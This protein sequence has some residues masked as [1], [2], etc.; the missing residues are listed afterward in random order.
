MPQSITFKTNRCVFYLSIL[1]SMS[2]IYIA[3]T[4]FMF[5]IKIPQSSAPAHNDENDSCAPTP[6]HAPNS[7]TPVEVKSVESSALVFTHGETKTECHFPVPFHTTPTPFSSSPKSLTLDVKYAPWFRRGYFVTS[8]VPVQTIRSHWL[9]DLHGQF[10]Y[11]LL[12]RLPLLMIIDALSSTSLTNKLGSVAS[13]I[14]NMRTFL[15][16]SGIGI[17]LVLPWGSIVFLSLFGQTFL[18]AVFAFFIS[19]FFIGYWRSKNLIF[20]QVSDSSLLRHRRK[21]NFIFHIINT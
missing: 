7:L 6:C 20:S 5:E 19:T 3:S 18:V 14:T 12:P 17:D 9:P 8:I 15:S 10:N 21:E 16:S 13:T 11:F 2:K 4:A 1:K